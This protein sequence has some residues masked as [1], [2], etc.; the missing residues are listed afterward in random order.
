MPRKGKGNRTRLL[1]IPYGCNWR[2]KKDIQF[3]REGSRWA[4]PGIVVGDEQM[5]VYGG[6]GNMETVYSIITNPITRTR[7]HLTRPAIVNWKWTREGLSIWNHPLSKDEIAHLANQS[8]F[9]SAPQFLRALAPA[10]LLQDQQAQEPMPPE[11]RRTWGVRIGS[12]I[13]SR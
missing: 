4:G 11:Q 1:W 2:S 7:E 10:N 8:G 6:G 9:S 12:G 5:F 3:S 13:A